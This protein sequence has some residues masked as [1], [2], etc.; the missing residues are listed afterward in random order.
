MGRELR[1]VAKDFDWPLHKVWEGFQ[2]PFYEYQKKCPFCDGSGLNPATKQISDDWY[3][4]DDRSKQ[5]SHN[6]TQDEVQA[7]ID[8]DRLIDFTHTWSRETGWQEKNPPYIPTAEEVNAWSRR[9]MGHDSLNCCI[10]VEARAKR[11]GVYGLCEHCHGSGE[12]WLTPE[13]EQKHEDWEPTQPPKG[14]YYQ[15][16]ETV[17][18]GSPVSPAFETPEDLA[19]WMVSHDT[20]VTKDTSYEQWLKFIRG[21]GWAPSLVM[22]GGVLESGVQAI[23]D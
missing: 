3:A 10:C 9:G 23:S 4:F 6:I 14:D 11:L 5:W 13:Y 15:I 7:L 16:W 22:H 17:S 19:H 1:R 2:N 8:H 12:L 21:P 20:S 18:E